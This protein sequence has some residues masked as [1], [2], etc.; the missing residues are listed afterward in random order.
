MKCGRKLQELRFEEE[1]LHED[2]ASTEHP[3]RNKKVVR[4]ALPSLKGRNNQKYVG[5]GF[6]SRAQRSLQ[7]KEECNPLKNLKRNTT[8]EIY[9]VQKCKN[10]AGFV[11]QDD[12]KDKDIYVKFFSR[13][14]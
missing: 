2:V 6:D 10:Y 7:K 11:F 9:S 4:N 3:G 14:E 8:N 1:K 12:Q 13:V 5:P